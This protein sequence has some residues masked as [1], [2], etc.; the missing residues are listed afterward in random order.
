[1]KK[2]LQYLALIILTVIASCKKEMPCE[3]CATKNN[4]PPI[5]IAGP[6]QVI[7]LPADSVLLDGS[8]SSDPDGMISSYLWT[9]ISGP[10]SFTI[11][12]P[13]DS[14]T[15]VKTLVVGTYQFELKVTDADNLFSKDTMWV[16]V[17]PETPPPPSTCN[18][19]NRPYINATL[20]QIGTLSEGK[21]L[22][23]V[24][25]AGNKIVFAGGMTESDG[26]A[27][28]DIYD[29]QQNSW[30]TA[31]L[32]IHRFNMAVTTCGNKIFFAGGA[33]ADAFSYSDSYKNVDVY[34]ASTNSWS[35][36]FLSEAKQNVAATSLGNKVFFAGGLTEGLGFQMSGKVEVYD[37]TTNQWSY[38][39]LSLPR[40]GM[41][42]DVVGNKVYFA[43]GN[44]AYTWTS[45]PV[46]HPTNRIDIYDNITNQWSVDYLTETKWGQASIKVGNKIY[47]AGG[48]SERVDIKDVSTQNEMIDCLTHPN[49]GFQAVRKGD[50]L[51]FFTG[52]SGSVQ[53]KFDIYNITTN[54]WSIGILPINIYGVS[55]IS[56][57]NTI[58]VAGGS[59]WGNN[60]LTIYDQVWKLEF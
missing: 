45:N 10:S 13:T 60:T 50:N 30:A 22:I 58:Y 47:W 19:G 33:S 56:V 11:L 18:S 24:G 51:I 20:T 44:T 54:T 40:E 48:Y 39:N 29:V 4:K 16:N 9:K 53:N 25:A 12:K 55:I 49:S 35:V 15:R 37:I 27:T 26:S 3:G 31:Q 42:A 36:I 5:A 7:T 52:N 28:V 8:N 32:S 1:M 2:I 38:M 23:A 41:T 34:D 17:K 57:N 46:H 43:G 21:T 59:S 6:D 14:I